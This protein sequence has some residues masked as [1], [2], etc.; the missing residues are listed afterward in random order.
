MGCSASS[1]ERGPTE[2][3]RREAAAARRAK[4]SAENSKI[5][6]KIQELESLIVTNKIRF[7][8]CV[9]EK[10]IEGARAISA[11]NVEIRKEISSHMRKLKPTTPNPNRNGLGLGGAGPASMRHIVSSTMSEPPPSVVLRDAQGPS[12]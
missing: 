6:T 7:A 10:N 1:C 12:L 8:Q 9:K 2:D 11:Q 4:L 3:E 5:S